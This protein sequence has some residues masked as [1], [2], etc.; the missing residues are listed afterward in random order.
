MSQFIVLGGDSVKFCQEKKK[1]KEKSMSNIV[2]FTLLLV[3]T[4]GR[5]SL[6]GPRWKKTES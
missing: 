3:A 4:A 5:S 1:K 6:V 2:E